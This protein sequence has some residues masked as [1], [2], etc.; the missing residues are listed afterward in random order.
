MTSGE[1]SL[2]LLS[3]CAICG[4]MVEMS[5]AIVGSGVAK[6]CARTGRPMDEYDRSQEIMC[7]GKS[8]EGIPYRLCG[9]KRESFC[10]RRRTLVESEEPDING[11]ESANWF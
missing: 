10:F 1:L 4:S 9:S 6:C 11:A 5:A 3:R 7:A 8:M 2:Y